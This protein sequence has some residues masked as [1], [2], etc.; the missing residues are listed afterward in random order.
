MPDRLQEWVKK[1]ILTGGWIG[2]DLFFVLS[3]FL[4]TGILLRTKK[5]PNY[6]LN[7]Y[8]RRILRIFPLYYAALI[9]LFIAL[10]ALGFFSEARFEP[11]RNAQAVHWLYATNF[12][13][14]LLPKEVLSV[15][16]IELRH[17]WSLAVEEHFYLF[18]PAL[19]WA[20]NPKPLKQVCIGLI[21]S[22]L[23]F[24][25]LGVY[26][27]ASSGYFTLTFC[28]WDALAAGALIAVLVHSRAS[29]I[30]RMQVPAIAVTLLGSAY[31][32]IFFF[33]NKG[34]WAAAPMMLTVGLSVIAATFAGLVV[35]A[36]NPANAVAQCLD[37]SPL[38]F[39]G[40][41]SYGLYV[42]HGLMTPLLLD[43][44]PADRWIAAFN[45]W[46]FVAVFS[47]A[48]VKTAICSALA[49]ISFHFYEMPFLQMKQYFRS[50]PAKFEAA[51]EETIPKVRDAS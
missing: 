10:P 27:G 21:V 5:D 32:L 51:T 4:I 14:W 1:A 23:A 26:L 7:F 50:K 37:I 22:A 19:V 3:G 17:F 44:F 38:R 48:A 40:K 43:F 29:T 9:V 36:M 12:A 8:A 41:Y 11:I 46:T 6:F 25:L 30:G 2:V 24:R 45:G 28:R 13:F 42:I 15:H 31:L 33:A 39:F 18:W 20:L 16:Y 34:L 47:L 49:I 35:L